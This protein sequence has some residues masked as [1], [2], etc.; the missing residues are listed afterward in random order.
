LADEMAGKT[1]ALMAWTTLLGTPSKMGGQLAMQKKLAGLTVLHCIGTV[2]LVHKH[3]QQICYQWFGSTLKQSNLAE[4]P[5]TDQGKVRRNTMYESQTDIYLRLMD[6]ACKTR[7]WG[8]G[9]CRCTLAFHN[10]RKS[11]SAEDQYYFP[12]CIKGILQP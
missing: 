1:Q 5:T 10:R 9:W 2:H 3:I 12:E 11:L 8:R 6:L 7:S 4:G